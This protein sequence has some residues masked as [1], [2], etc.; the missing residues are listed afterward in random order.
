[1]NKKIKI[2]ADNKIP[3]FKGVLDD[4]AEIQYLNPNEI[5]N[6]NIK[7]TDALIIRTRTICNA[8][9][10]NDT[11]VKFI[12]TAT[13]GY[14]HIDTEY[15]KEKNIKWMNAPGCNSSSVMQYVSSA[16]LTIADKKNID[17]SNSTVGII[18]VGNVGSK[19]AKAA[20][21]FGMNVLLNDPPRKRNEGGN[22]FVDLDYLIS[23]S[24][25]ITF[26]VPLN[27]SGID[28][29]YHLVD[30]TFINKL[31]ENT[32]LF[33]TSRGS[34]VKTESLKNA[35]TNRKI[36]SAVLDVWENEPEINLELLSLVDI[37]TPHIAGY[38][39]D[40]KA[41]G[42]SVCV[43]GIAEFFNLDFDKN[44]YPKEMPNPENY[45]EIIIECK[46]K[47]EQEIFQNA[48]LHSYNILE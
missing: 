38:S 1:M 32:I 13:I 44:W 16:L 15:C 26:H 10:L 12:A 48:V 34:V 14:D 5:T 3:F 35:L 43:N 46:N 4:A 39:A 28:K 23:K 2:I 29:T 25:F 19:V 31:K 21:I 47:S 8:D 22:K 45:S 37:A 24:D 17:L 33:N 36:N 41:N 27:K 6:Q 20:S 11:N 9:L 7:E 30:D 18:G 40:G 42:T